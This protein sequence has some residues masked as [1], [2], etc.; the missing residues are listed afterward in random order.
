[1]DLFDLPLR[2]LAIEHHSS[3]DMRLLFFHPIDHFLLHFPFNP[4]SNC[5]LPF[6]PFLLQF[7]PDLPLNLP[8]LPLQPLP[9]LP[10]RLPR[11]HR[12]TLQTIHQ[13]PELPIIID[14]VECESQSLIDFF[15]VGLAVFEFGD[16][17]VQNLAT[18]QQHDFLAL[19]LVLFGREVFAAAQEFVL[20]REEGGLWGGGL[21]GWK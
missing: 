11:R 12:I 3:P 10:Q 15:E 20:E 19:P 4:F 8:T 5:P 18:L 17:H 7:L 16:L 13:S 9:I 6:P 2:F 21:R 14:F 1:M